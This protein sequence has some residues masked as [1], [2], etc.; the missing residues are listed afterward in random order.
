MP[1]DILVYICLVVCAAW[2][3]SAS[4]AR[5]IIFYAVVI[6]GAA[7]ILAP[8]LGM[9]IDASGLLSLLSNPK[10]SFGLVVAIVLSRLLCAPYWIWR[11]DQKTISALREDH[12]AERQ[13]RNR[14]IAKLREFYAAIGTII[15]RQLPKEISEDD[16]NK[17][18][19][20]EAQNL[21]TNCANWIAENI[22]NPARQRFLDLTGKLMMNTPDA[23]N[24]THRTILLNLARRSQNLL[25]LIQNY[26]AWDGK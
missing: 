15:E 14:N 8:I 7:A 24:E 16:F 4:L 20:E 5:T 6:V 13:R 25:E 22:G 19:V 18:Y 9:T 23:V 11:D 17:H 1:R 10:F 2:G 21:L 12:T 26:D 3:H